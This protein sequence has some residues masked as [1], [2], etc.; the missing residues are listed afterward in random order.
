MEYLTCIEEIHALKQKLVL[1]LS[2]FPI[3]PVCTA[4]LGNPFSYLE[5][6]KDECVHNRTAI[7]LFWLRSATQSVSWFTEWEPPMCWESKP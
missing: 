6:N 4:Q 5:Q 1:L 3:I 7:H 2:L